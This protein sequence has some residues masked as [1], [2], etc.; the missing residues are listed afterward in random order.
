MLCPVGD[1]VSVRDQVLAATGAQARVIDAGGVATSIL[2]AGD[3]P[4]LLLLHG[5]IESGAAIW[6][7]V[8]DR[9]AASHRVL[10]PDLP[11]LGASPPMATLDHG[12]FGS[13]LRATLRA[14]GMERPTVVA[15]SL[16]GSLGARFASEAPGTISRLVVYGA[17][18]IARYRMPPRLMYSAI[19]FSL[20]PT[21]RNAERFDRFLLFDLDATRAR[22]AG[23]YEAFDEYNRAQA[24]VPHVKKTM[25]ALVS[26]ATK[27]IPDDDLDRI[28]GPV[29]L[30]WGRHDR[31][32]PLEV[33]R[34]AE[35]RHGWPLHLVDDAAHAPHLEQ[36]EAFLEALL[37]LL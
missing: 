13:W 18:G 5:G 11:G 34:A 19:R 22:H 20:R 7:P 17:P 15:H 2:E 32:V 24:R 6:V 30:L 33:G 12:T 1:Q 31:M 3:G 8:L 9:L 27:Q 16:G 25:N 35:E 26:L 28:D 36:P 23:W 21:A 37:P 29:H 14:V 10:A 4:P